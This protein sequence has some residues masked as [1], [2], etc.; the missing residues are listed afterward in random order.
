M[1]LQREKERT[2]D[3]IENEPRPYKGSALEEFRQ[4][5]TPK[6]YGEG[7]A[8]WETWQEQE[9][10]KSQKLAMQAF[11]EMRDERKWWARYNQEI[12]EGIEA[13]AVQ[14]PPVDESNT[15]E[16]LGEESLAEE[17]T[18]RDEVSL[19]KTQKV[20]DEDEDF[21]PSRGTFEAEVTGSHSWGKRMHREDMSP[22]K[23]PIR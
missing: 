17:E 16:S 20:K 13:E 8:D 21:G 1:R 14:D 22:S 4:S 9:N 12:R 10:V 3:H 2:H 15:D 18:W 11:L 19:R 5:Y 23:S 7:E 6:R